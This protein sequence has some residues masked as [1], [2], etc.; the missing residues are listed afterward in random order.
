MAWSWSRALLSGKAPPGADLERSG[1][2][3]VGEGGKGPAEDSEDLLALVSTLTPAVKRAMEEEI[4]ADLHRADTFFLAAIHA[5]PTLP[6]LHLVRAMA[7]IDLLPPG[8]ALET[9]RTRLDK[10]VGNAVTLAPNRPSTLFKAARFYGREILHDRGGIDFASEEG[11]RILDMFRRAVASA[12]GRYGPPTFAF[13]LEEARADPNLL[14]EVTPRTYPARRMLLGFLKARRRWP[15]ALRSV[16]EMLAL[17][18]LDP[19]GTS[20]PELEAGTVEFKRIRAA[21]L[22][23]LRL[24]QRTGRA[25][26]WKAAASRYNAIQGLRCRKLLDRVSE[27]EG[28]GRY[29]EAMKYCGD[30]LALDWY[31][32]DAY[33]KLTE[34]RLRPGMY[35][36]RLHTEEI[37]RELLRLLA[38]RNAWTLPRCTLLDRVLAGLEPGETVVGRARAGLVTGLGHLRCGDPAAGARLLCE[39]LPTD[40]PP[41]RAW[42]QAHLVHYYLGRALERTGETTQALVSYEKALELAPTHR[43]SLARLAA[44][45]RPATARGRDTDNAAGPPPTG[46]SAPSR[47]E[48]PIPPGEPAG[49]QP[50]LITGAS[51][52]APHPVVPRAERIRGDRP[53]AAQ[54]KPARAAGDAP[55]PQPPAPADHETGPSL[56]AEGP[57]SPRPTA[58]ER[59]QGLTPRV[60]WGIDFSGKVT[61]LGITLENPSAEAAGPGSQGES[62]RTSPTAGPAKRGRVEIPGTAPSG[63]PQGATALAA[64]H[65]RGAAAAGSFRAGAAITEPTHVVVRCFWEVT[66]ELDPTDY[67]VLYRYYDSKG[68]FVH[69]ERRPLLGRATV[70]GARGKE[71]PGGIGTVLVHR[72]DLFLYS[73]A[74]R[75]VRIMVRRRRHG[76]RPPEPLRSITGDR[77]VPLALPE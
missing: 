37:F 2:L 33:L 1:P 12:P 72:N 32:L 42:N 20:L 71:P 40:V 31:N 9:E 53:A 45:E 54:E 65:G 48:P 73:G 56:Q 59:L 11:A 6:W 46:T 41:L 64:P 49:A 24:L 26:A 74:P 47:L 21:V 10:W 35:R 60:A 66:E 7:Y 68:S 67:E 70:D 52:G 3:G 38:A 69:R 34:I 36:V 55:P 28:K 4:R 17:C 51:G 25:A 13:L 57:G 39:L 75:E 18:G 15:E 27:L 50:A 43:A 76:K 29:T 16:E 19:R 58:A 77:W 44:L 8:R 61:L 14:F 23:Q 22:W 30:C 5:A 62:T 63:R